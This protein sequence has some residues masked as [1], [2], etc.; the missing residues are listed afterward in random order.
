MTSLSQWKTNFSAGV[1]KEPVSYMQAV[2]IVDTVQDA[3]DIGKNGPFSGYTVRTVGHSKGGGEAAYAALNRQVPLQSTGFCSAHLSQGLIDRI[4]ETNPN[5]LNSAPALVQTFSPFKD[6][7]SGLRNLLP[8]LPGV[9]TGYHFN[10]DETESLI[11]FH[12]KVD[13]HF[14]FFQENIDVFSRS[15]EQSRSNSGM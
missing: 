9:G 12:A 4:N 2:M 5:N 3:T 1:G 11:T 8:N 7:V 6:P 10:G 14:S 15:M 13:M